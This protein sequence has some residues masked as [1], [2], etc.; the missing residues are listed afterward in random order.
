MLAIHSLSLSKSLIS[1]NVF[2]ELI[3]SVTNVWVIPLDLA[4]VSLT[5]LSLV[6]STV[7]SKFVNHSSN[8]AESCSLKTAMSCSSEFVKFVCFCVVYNVSVYWHITSL[9]DSEGV[10]VEVG[11]ILSMRER[12]CSSC[13]MWSSPPAGWPSLASTHCYKLLI[14]LSVWLSLPG[15]CA[16]GCWG[17]HLPPN[18]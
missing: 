6:R 7:V 5:W 4:L 9:K 15:C 14:L 17:S 2:S 10:G 1:S 18:L 8:F 12:F 11:C 13:S 16:E 3:A